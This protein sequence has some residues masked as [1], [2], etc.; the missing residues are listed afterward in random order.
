MKDILLGS[1]KSE[2]N[3]DGLLTGEISQYYWRDQPV[4]AFINEA[5]M[6]T[7]Q[8]CI[9]RIDDLEYGMPKD[10]FGQVA[11]KIMAP[12]GEIDQI[13]CQVANGSNQLTHTE[14]FKDMISEL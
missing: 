1:L 11:R 12:F 2:S 8:A 9:K 10:L 3:P 13:L 4:I 5:C 6:K 14:K 7:E